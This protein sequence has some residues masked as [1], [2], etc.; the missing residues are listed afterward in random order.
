MLSEKDLHILKKQLGRMPRG[1]VAIAVRHKDRTPV[2]TV[3]YPLHHEDAPHI[4]HIHEHSPCPE[5]LVPFPTLF[6]LTCPVLHRK[7]ADLERRGQ[8]D[9]L[10]NHINHNAELEHTLTED[11]KSYIDLRWRLM[12]KDDQQAA[13]ESPCLLETLRARGIGG[14]SNFLTLKCLHLHY[15][16]HLANLPQGGTTV[17]RLLEADNPQLIDIR[18]QFITEPLAKLFPLP[19]GSPPMP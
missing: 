1:V 16:H 13:L 8:I 17:G 18:N 12:N 3:N 14:I 15:A 11:H 6:W 7:L 4:P 2:V 9:H 10:Q 5:K 19:P